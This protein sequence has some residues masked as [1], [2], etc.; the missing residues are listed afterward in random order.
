MMTYGTE[1]PLAGFCILCKNKAG[2]THGRQTHLR[3]SNATIRLCSSRRDPVTQWSGSK[4]PDHGADQDCE[5][6]EA[7]RLRAVVIRWSGKVLRLC[8]VDREERAARPGHHKGRELHDWECEQLPWDPEVRKHALPGVG[9]RRVDTPLTFA[10]RS[11]SKPGITVR[12]RS[13]LEW[14]VTLNACN[15]ATTF[16][17]ILPVISENHSRSLSDVSTYVD[18][19]LADVSDVVKHIPPDCQHYS[20]TWSQLS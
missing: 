12:G 6:H 19:E 11:F 9:G 3:L 20:M 17:R 14:V 8:E 1:S 15:V 4:E 2:H 5:V 16:L 10:R 7:D 13:W 18:D